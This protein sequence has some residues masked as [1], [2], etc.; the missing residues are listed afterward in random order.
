[1]RIIIII[2]PFPCSSTHWSPSNIRN[3]N[4]STGDS[5]ITFGQHNIQD[6]QDS[7]ATV[8][9]S[10]HTNPLSINFSMDNTMTTTVLSESTP[11]SDST[12]VTT[13]QSESTTTTSTTDSTMATTALTESTTTTDNTMVTTDQTDSTTDTSN[14]LQI[15]INFVQNAVSTQHFAIHV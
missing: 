6:G 8:S 15:T 3:G 9:R 5:A 10:V 12:L 11:T 4:I 2:N 7:L 13:A 1:M 14:V